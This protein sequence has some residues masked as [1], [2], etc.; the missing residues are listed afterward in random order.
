MDGRSEVAVFVDKIVAEGLD[1]VSA[2]AET[3]VAGGPGRGIEIG[4]QGPPA[5]AGA[6]GGD[7]DRT[8]GFAHAA[9]VIDHYDDLH[10]LSVSG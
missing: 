8:G 1:P 7:I 9:F 6:P 2:G 5:E 3:Q 10:F 4:E